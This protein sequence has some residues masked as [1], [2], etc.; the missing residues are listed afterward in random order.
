MVYDFITNMHTVCNTIMT[1]T[2]YD[3]VKTSAIIATDHRVAV[4]ESQ[5]MVFSL[6]CSYVDKCHV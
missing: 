3:S 5:S 2:I 6:L 4:S 1:M